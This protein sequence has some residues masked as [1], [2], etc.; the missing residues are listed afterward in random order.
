MFKE[1]QNAPVNTVSQNITP[2]QAS[3]DKLKMEIKDN[4]D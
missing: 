4:N 3:L 2:L 1:Q